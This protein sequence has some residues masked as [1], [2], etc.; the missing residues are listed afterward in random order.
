MQWCRAPGLIP[1]RCLR[2]SPT[3]AEGTGNQPLALLLQLLTTFRAHPVPW[4]HQLGPKTVILG[5]N[6]MAVPALVLRDP[7]HARVRALSRPGSRRYGIAQP[8][9]APR[10]RPAACRVNEASSSLLIAPGEAVAKARRAPS[11]PRP[12][13]KRQ[14]HGGGSETP[15]KNEAEGGWVQER[16]AAREEET[17]S[18]R[19]TGTRPLRCRGHP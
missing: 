6:P 12:T 1:Y 4:Q 17:R 11:R 16:R 5:H 15:S 2:A 8:S 18:G 9:A 14:P 7:L 13:E 10:V 3:T 19:M